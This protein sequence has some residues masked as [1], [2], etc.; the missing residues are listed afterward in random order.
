MEHS[1]RTIYKGTF[2]HLSNFK[3]TSDS[4]AMVIN[5]LLWFWFG[6]RTT[7]KT[8]LWWMVRISLSGIEGFM[9]TWDVL[10]QTSRQSRSQCIKLK[11]FASINCLLAV[12]ASEVVQYLWYFSSMIP[13]NIQKSRKTTLWPRGR[14]SA[15]SFPIRDRILH[16]RETIA[17]ILPKI[18]FFL[19]RS[20]FN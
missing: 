18:L 10:S 14:R 20:T 2:K 4:R 16:W 8:S 9:A 15:L 1:I 17:Q 12:K 19:V 3:C 13:P 5:H 7:N 6:N 11:M